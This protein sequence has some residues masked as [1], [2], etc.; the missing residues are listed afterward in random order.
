MAEEGPVIFECILD[1]ERLA[2]FKDCME[3][4]GMDRNAPE[5][6]W[7][8]N[9]ISKKAIALTCGLISRRGDQPVHRHQPAEFNLCRILATQASKIMMGQDVGMGSESRDPFRPYYVVNSIGKPAP[10]LITE[11]L[12]RE[13]FGGTI[14][15][16]TQ[17]VIE[18]LEESG[19]W[20]RQ[21]LYDYDGSDD[22]DENNLRP[23]QAM[24]RW[25]H[26]NRHLQSPAFVMILCVK[27]SSLKPPS[28]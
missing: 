6:E 24:I 11:S 12:I 3:T 25:F 17:I 10:K 22:E 27:L 1:A 28:F 16:P 21:V 15:P 20:W 2:V 19:E 14:Y 26:E 5:S 18:P 8:W 23:W 7:P 4:Y 13:V 9:V